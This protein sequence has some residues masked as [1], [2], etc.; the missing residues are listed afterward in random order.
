MADASRY[1][2]G[3]RFII[4]D[5][6][7][8]LE[9]CRQTHPLWHQGRD[10]GSYVERVREA[11]A[12][13]GPEMRY[14]GLVDDTG[15]LMASAR[16]LDGGLAMQGCSLPAM[17]IAAV[18]VPESRRGQGLGRRLMQALLD[19]ARR[20]GCA[21]AFLFS[22]IGPAY[23]EPIGFQ[24]YPA[25]DWTAPAAA[26]PE[27]SPLAIRRARPED[28]A[29]MGAW[30]RGTSGPDALCATRTSRWW[31]YFRWWRDALEDYILYDGS[32]EVGY[33]NVAA[34][35][36][37]L[38]VYEWAAPAIEAERVWAT[39]RARAA[40]VGASRVAGWLHPGRREAWMEV[41]ERS[42]AV[43]MVAAVD[44]RALPLPAQAAFEE[45]DHF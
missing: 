18:F 39:V 5:D 2:D 41:A 29:R 20:R 44:E 6:D 12:R 34:R 1:S 30:L 35:S 10:F 15:E 27:R 26:L 21:A 37:A 3:L 45:L 43:P 25:L 4:L 11:L 8:V 23:Y 19:D 14:A 22:D 16:E 28:M 36:D 38:R 31:E 17:G 32:H 9:A 13:M 40:D 33:C 7:S 42:E 24:A